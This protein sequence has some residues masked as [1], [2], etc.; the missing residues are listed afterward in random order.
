MHRRVYIYILY[1][2]I[3]HIIELALNLNSCSFSRR[4]MWLKVCTSPSSEV[5]AKYF[6]D[7]VKTV[8]GII[9]IIGCMA[10][11]TMYTFELF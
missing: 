10:T 7:C 4:I 2:L 5:I 3:I 8:D 6:V 9:I 11:Y 1:I